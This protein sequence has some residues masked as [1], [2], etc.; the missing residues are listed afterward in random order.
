MTSARAVAMPRRV[1]PEWLDELP[2]DAPR[3]R[4]ARRDLRRINL[5]MLQTLIMARLLLR[6]ARQPPRTILDLGAGDGTFMLGVARRL[7]ARWRGVTVL[8]LDRQDIV[9]SRTREA[10]A[11]LQWQVETISADVLH[12]ELPRADVITANLFVHHF[13]DGDLAALLAR[14]ASRTP[15]FVACEPRRGA[16]PLFCAKLC[17]AIGC[18]DV[19]RHDAAASVRAG[20]R[21]HELSLLWPD[22]ERWHLHERA[23]GL[24]S[25]CFVARQARPGSDDA[26]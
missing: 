8:L 1:E 9:G 25:H 6:H 12:A 13:R 4:R 26:L 19:S 2:A 23:A 5:C 24:F 3:A 10:F 11:A 15:L 7:A 21:G 14:A 22:R 20:F 18:N 16:W 17:W